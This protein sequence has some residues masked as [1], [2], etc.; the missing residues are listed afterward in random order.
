MISN[1]GLYIV[2][3]REGFYANRVHVERE[4]LVSE[5]YDRRAGMKLSFVG[6]RVRCEKTRISFTKEN[7]FRGIATFTEQNALGGVAA[8]AEQN[9]SHWIVALAKENAFGRIASLAK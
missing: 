7:A 5:G 1:G 9:A 6:D 3:N 4:S 2:L 8:F